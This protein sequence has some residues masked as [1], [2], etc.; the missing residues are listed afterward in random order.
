[1]RLEV[2]AAQR[3]LAGARVV[4]LHEVRGDSITPRRVSTKGLH[5]ET[6]RIAV[7]RGRKVDESV[8]PSLK[9]LH[10]RGGG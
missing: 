5:E 3:P 9:P 2:D 10:M 6:A 7:H 4:V 8:E 1:M